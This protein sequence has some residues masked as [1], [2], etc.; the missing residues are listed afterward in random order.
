MADKA[1]P[2]HIL[3]TR[4]RAASERF[5]AELARRGVAM[6][7]AAISPAISIE[8][9]GR[10]VDIEGHGGVIVTS[11]HALVG[12]TGRRGVS[13]WCVGDAT[14]RAAERAGFDAVTAG[15]TVDDLVRVITGA[16]PRSPLLYLRGQH[17]TGDVAGQLAGFGIEVDER[18]VY[19]QPESSP[20]ADAARLVS[21][22]ASVVLPLFS[23]RS[24]AIVAD[25]TEQA[26]AP[27]H[28][29]A[30]SEAVAAAWG[31][32]A[33]IAPRPTLTSMVDTTAELIAGLR[34]G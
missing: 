5:L 28:A 6:G 25:W 24:A 16:R 12:V 27:L 32:T 11:A 20:N 7:E 22:T 2:P 26:V 21:G 30:M 18:V 9:V 10:P 4:P 29:V 19:D 3:M 17:V 33:R 15:G 1:S 14:A 23:P 13:A 31:R 8:H 34:N